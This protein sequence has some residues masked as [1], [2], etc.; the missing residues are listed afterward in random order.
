MPGLVLALVVAFQPETYAPVLPVWKARYLRR[1]TGDD[2]YVAAMEIEG[3]PFIKRLGTAFCRP[4]LLSI[5]EPIV[6]L[7][8]LISR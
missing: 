3:E 2:G 6:V 7:V 8:R 4:F 5:R 1:L